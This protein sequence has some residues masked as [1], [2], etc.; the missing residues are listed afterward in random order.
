MQLSNTS[1]QS[2]C[3]ES[4]NTHHQ[5]NNSNLITEGWIRYYDNSKKTVCWK[6]QRTHEVY[7]VN[8]FLSES[9]C[10]IPESMRNHWYIVYDEQ[11]KRPFY[12]NPSLR[13]EQW[14]K[15]LLKEHVVKAY[16]MEEYASNHYDR[17]KGFFRKYSLESLLSYDPN[18]LTQPL[19]LMESN[20]SHIA[21]KI[22]HFIHLYL[23]TQKNDYIQ[24]IIA[25]CLVSPVILIDEC[26]CQLLKQ[27]S[28][29]NLQ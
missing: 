4:M 2:L 16:Y 21:L 7:K 28:R 12:I 19:L 9:E 29:C 6:N 22:N 3:N 1:F 5:S 24:K 20:L 15:P 8:P 14:E 23:K 18:E 26:Y 27:L 10:Q 25:Y 17:K 13:Q 11:K